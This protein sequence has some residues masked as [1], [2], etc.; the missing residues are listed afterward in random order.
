MGLKPKSSVFYLQK[1]KEETLGKAE[2]ED[3][4]LTP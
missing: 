4:V 1:S 2:W 3:K